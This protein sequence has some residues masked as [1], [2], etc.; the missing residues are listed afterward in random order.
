[1]SAKPLAVAVLFCVGA[2]LPSHSAAAQN[3]KV[4]FDKSADFT[5][6]QKY[7]WGSNYLLTQQPKLETQT[8]D[9]IPLFTRT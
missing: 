7:S 2:L 6:Y 5:K 1:M 4:S 3:V 8:S 9:E